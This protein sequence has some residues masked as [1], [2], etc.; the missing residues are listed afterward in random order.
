MQRVQTGLEV[1]LE[2]PELIG[3][4]GW[5]LVANHAAVTSDLDPARTA[6]KAV[7]PGHGGGS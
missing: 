1:L 7:D 3:G 6:L 4:R 2:A 5:A